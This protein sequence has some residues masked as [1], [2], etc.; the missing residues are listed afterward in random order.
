M[1]I[2]PRRLLELERTYAQVNGAISEDVGNIARARQIAEL[3]L[4]A[5]A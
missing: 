3:H 4:R 5:A 2:F 1:A